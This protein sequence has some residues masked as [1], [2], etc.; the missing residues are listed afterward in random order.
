MTGIDEIR[1]RHAICA[2][3]RVS[4]RCVSEI[5]TQIFLIE[6]ILNLLGIDT[7]DPLKIK[8][9]NRSPKKP[10][11]DIEVYD[12]AGM[13]KFAIECK[14]L[15]S[16]GFNIEK[17]SCGQLW[18]EGSRPKAWSVGDY[19]AKHGDCVGQLRGYCKRRADFGAAVPI[20]TNGKTWVVFD[21]QFLENVERPITK[22]DERKLF[23]V[24]DLEDEAFL[25]NLK[26][27]LE[28]ERIE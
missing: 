12:N 6:P 25:P 14:S 26:K 4:E 10:Q 28:Q 20:L 1:S 27:K 18:K 2:K 9:A 17:W 11:F 13:L 15:S 23:F 24:F 7:L 5:D 3:R 19:C 21:K 8:R 16:G 22:D